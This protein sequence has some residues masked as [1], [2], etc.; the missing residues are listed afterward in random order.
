[1]FFAFFTPFF[2]SFFKTI[3]LEILGVLI[4]HCARFYVFSAKNCGEI[5]SQSW[6]LSAI[7]FNFPIVQ[8]SSAVGCRGF[9]LFVWKFGITA[10][11]E[12]MHYGEV[13]KNSWK[14]STLGAY[15]SAVF[16][17][18]IRKI[19]HNAVL[20]PQEC[21][22]KIVLKKMKKKGVKRAKNMLLMFVK[23]KLGVKKI[24]LVNA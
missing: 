13:E 23:V 18:K 17:Q 5:S 4:Q 10:I 2:F 11:R 9:K 20:T 19:L 3:F 15:F 7:F 8:W 16:L 12:P 6:P 21:L 1:M 24:V 22:N 14:W